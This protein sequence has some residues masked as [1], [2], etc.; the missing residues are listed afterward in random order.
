MSRT[1]LRQIAPVQEKPRQ[2]VAVRIAAC[3][4]RLETYCN[5]QG[6]RKSSARRKIVEVI[7]RGL[8]HFTP[9]ELVLRVV[10]RHPELGKRYS[11]PNH[12]CSS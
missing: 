8:L 12:S 9:Q 11:L 10:E 2:N 4:E 7:V 5:E 6:L 1:L 3:V